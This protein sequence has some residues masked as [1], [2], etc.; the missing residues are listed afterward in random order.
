MQIK[1]NLTIST[2]DFYYDLTYGGSIDPY[3]ICENE[4]DAKEVEKA[5]AVIKD[6][7]ESCEE[8]IEN[9]IQ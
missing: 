8:Q 6:F 4:E 9:F 3:D 1:K 7:Q 2:D 5:I